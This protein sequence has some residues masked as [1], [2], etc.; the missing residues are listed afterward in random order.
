MLARHDVDAI[1]M[2]CQM[3]V[4]D[5]FEATRLIRAQPRLARIPILAMTANAMSGDRERCLAAGMNEHISKPIHQEELVMVLAQWMPRASAAA[6]PDASGDQF[7][8]LRAAGVDV[9]WGLNRLHGN[10]I[11][12]RKLLL[13]IGQLQAWLADKLRDALAAGQ[14]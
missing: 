2:D 12:Y 5:G 3:P 4:M 14:A 1:L 11:A 8:P 13:Q 9:G 7:A 10:D 6:V